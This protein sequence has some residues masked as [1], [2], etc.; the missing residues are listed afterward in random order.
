MRSLGWESLASEALSQSPLPCYSLLCLMCDLL[1]PQY[2]L[3]TP[4]ACLQWSLVIPVCS[5]G[6]WLQCSSVTS[7]VFEPVTCFP[8]P[9]WCPICSS[10]QLVT[11]T[12]LILWELQLASS[13]PLS[14]CLQHSSDFTTESKYLTVTRNLLL[15][16]LVLQETHLYYWTPVAACVG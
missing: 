3:V 5:Q 6:S 8:A 7:S 15:L 4:W 11:C 16:L 13:V 1:S 14:V 10:L 9:V 12:C 2:F